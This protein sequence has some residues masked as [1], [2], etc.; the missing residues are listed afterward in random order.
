MKLR[1]IFLGMV[2][3]YTLSSCREKIDVDLD[4]SQHHVPTLNYIAYAKPDGSGDITSL[5]LSETRIGRPR[6]IKLQSLSL[7]VN[8]EE[9]LHSSDYVGQELSNG[10][11]T[12]YQ[13]PAVYKAEEHVRLSA[14]LEG[15]KVLQVEQVIPKVPLL[16]EA[17]L[18]TLEESKTPG[19]Y[20]RHNYPLTLRLQDHKGSANH[21]RLRCQLVDLYRD[22]TQGSER[23]ARARRIEADYIKDFILMDGSPI[24]D[25]NT[26]DVGDLFETTRNNRYLVFDD[27]LFADKEANITLTLNGYDLE[28]TDTSDLHI[29]EANGAVRSYQY[30]HTELQ[31]WVEG[32]TAGAFYYYKALGQWMSEDY[33][34]ASL[35]TVPTKIPSNVKDGAGFFGVFS[36]SE[37][38]RIIRKLN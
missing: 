35:F 36:Q 18:G 13:F 9:R 3:S 19:V 29:V 38:K 31:V 8:G 25:E 28:Y 16:L 11:L 37:I 12:L 34:S 4:Q 20:T 14:T 22:E 6:A 17:Q 32:I 30:V 23:Y 21:Y 26:T 27:H 24:M 5:Y 7:Q 2:L 33:D 10:A 15:G 1:Y